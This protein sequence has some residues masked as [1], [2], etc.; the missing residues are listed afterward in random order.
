MN[1]MVNS[2]E[3]MKGMA[4]TRMLSI[5][6]RPGDN[7]EV[8]LSVTDTG[9][10]LP[11]EV[12]RIFDAFFTTKARGTGMGLRITRSIIES[13]GRRV[14]AAPNSSRGASFHINLPRRP[15]Q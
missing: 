13:H 2:I 9:V 14:W 10:G 4:G 8:L 3:A 15:A 11:K 1:L 7:Q 12:D 6:S 5:R